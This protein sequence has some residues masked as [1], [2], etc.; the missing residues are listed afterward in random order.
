MKRYMVLAAL[1]CIIAFSCKKSSADQ[2][3]ITGKWE[4]REE[5]GGIAGKISYEPGKGTLWVFNSNGQF[6]TVYINGPAISG[7][8]QL[9]QSARAGDYLLKLQ[10]NQNGQAQA[11][12][13]SVR[14]EKNQ[15]LVLP[16]AVCCDIP[17]SYYERLP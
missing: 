7:S 4:L 10:Y 12:S 8:Y 2:R 17:T 1:V 5:V 14:F 15:W 13:D 9:Q 6:Q 11:R 3:L 16:F